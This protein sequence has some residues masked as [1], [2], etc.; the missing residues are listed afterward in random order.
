MQT[1]LTATMLNALAKRPPEARTDVHDEQ[2]PGLMLR[3]TP[4]GTMTWSYQYRLAGAGGISARGH[5]LKGKG[6]H[7]LTLGRYPEISIA[8]A[9]RV[10]ADYQSLAKKGLDPKAQLEVIAD[11]TKDSVEDLVKLFLEKHVS[12]NK[13][14]SEWKIRIAFDTHILPKWKHRSASS[15]TRQD[16]RLL[17]ETASKKHKR[18]DGRYEGGPEAART[19]REVLSQLFEWACVQELVPANPIAGFK[20]LVKK[21][22]R[23]R[24]LSMEELQAIWK[25][26]SITNYPFGPMVK[27]L[28][29]TACRRG[30]W[31]G[32]RWS[33]INFKDHLME[34]PSDNYKSKRVHVVP[35]SK[36]A[37]EILKNTKRWDEGDYTFSG[38]KGE[39]PVS[40]F[41]RA[42]TIIDKAV[43]E[44]L[45]RQLENWRLHDL[46]RSVATHLRRLGV[47]RQVVKHILGHADK[48]ATA[49]YDRYSLL[50]ER[51]ETL[52]MWAEELIV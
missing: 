44:E 36:Q 32:A 10:A 21:Q 16:A 4:K 2:V 31:A 25:A 3:V 45:E 49:I 17:I 28:L 20:D 27:L 37:L 52:Q 38:T 30:E 7:R 48:D 6:R 19:T 9:R 22:S 11:D 34:I 24:V 41:S 40:G 35:L 42:K 39:R 12:A 13:L 14:R 33:W 46:R 8:E 23:D 43:D 29:L 18:K 1:R 15:I 5:A 50:P 26:S 47:D 51:R